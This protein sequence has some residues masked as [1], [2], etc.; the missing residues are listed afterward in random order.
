MWDVTIW[1]TSVHLDHCDLNNLQVE[2]GRLNSKWKNLVNWSSIKTHKME[3]I[4][5]YTQ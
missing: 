3:M 1:P 2:A 4:Y 5:F